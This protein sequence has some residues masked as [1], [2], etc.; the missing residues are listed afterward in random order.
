MSDFQRRIRSASLASDVLLL[1]VTSNGP[2]VVV[3][4]RGELEALSSPRLS[5]MVTDLFPGGVP[6]VLVL[7][8]EGVTFCGAA[9]IREL[10]TVRR[11]VLAAGGRV[12]LRA[13][14][15]LIRRALTAT[16]DL[17]YFEV[18]DAAEGAA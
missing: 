6:P 5:D 14:P 10:L 12:I 16:G 13:L 18:E 3:R 2:D 4:L 11:A 17:W 7:N 1:S 8:L 9:G 15:P